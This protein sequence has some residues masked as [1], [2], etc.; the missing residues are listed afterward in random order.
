MTNIPN[1][2]RVPATVT[3]LRSLTPARLNRLRHHIANDRLVMM[4]PCDCLVGFEGGYS[5]LVR[6]PLAHAAEAEMLRYPHVEC[7]ESDDT[8]RQ[9][10]D[11]LLPIIDH[12]IIEKQEAARAR[13]NVRG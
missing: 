5:V 10:K 2:E 6:K 7:L 12:I 4:R 13:K 11:V 3:Y 1:E 9:R 8:N